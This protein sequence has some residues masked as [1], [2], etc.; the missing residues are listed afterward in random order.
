MTSFVNI[1]YPA[2]HPGVV[3]F[4][5]AVG[6]ARELRKGFD[7][8]RGLAGLLLAAI[9][10][11][12]VVVA[13]QLV[14]N[15]AEGHLLVVWVAMWAVAFSVMALFAGTAR[16]LAARVLT[17][18]DA[19]SSAIAQARADV[20]LWEAAKADP[21]VMADLQGAMARQENM[22]EAASL[23]SVAVAAAVKVR[24]AKPIDLGSR[25]LRAYP[26]YYI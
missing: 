9:V 26:S 18:L 15:W 22:D 19:W 2:E 13:D 3:R 24:E 4:E 25:V 6:A 17:A 23:P 21:R 12:M 16:Q 5:S 14:E 7:S 11:A 20:R 8:T 1:N 10:A